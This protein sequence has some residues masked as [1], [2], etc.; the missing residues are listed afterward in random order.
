MW[1]CVHFLA[2][3]LSGHSGCLCTYQLV[4][5]SFALSHIQHDCYIHP[6]SS[7]NWFFFLFNYCL[8]S[9]YDCGDAAVSIEC[10]RSTCTCV[11]VIVG[12]CVFYDFDLYAIF[13]FV[14]LTV[15]DVNLWNFQ[16]RCAAH[17]DIYWLIFISLLC[18]AIWILLT[19][20]SMRGANGCADDWYG[21][22]VCNARSQVS[23]NADM[24][25]PITMGEAKTPR[26][27]IQATGQGDISFFEDKL[28]VQ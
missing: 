7:N 4:P 27:W 6:I 17:S 8:Y 22:S 11:W 28:C 9:H 20:R 24:V 13:Q 25:E 26:N 16:R 21:S 5:I 12:H 2:L 10:V 15:C 19:W 14:P 3:S 23:G 18:V 1:L